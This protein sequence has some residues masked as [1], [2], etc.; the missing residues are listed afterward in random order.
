[1]GDVATHPDAGVAG[2]DAPARTTY[3]VAPQLVVAQ[4]V[5]VAVA[6]VPAPA[7]AST[8][9]S[10][11][12]VAW[13]DL[14]D[15]PTADRFPGDVLVVMEDLD[16]AGALHQVVERSRLPGHRVALVVP[17]ATRTR[18][19]EL[20]D[21]DVELAAGVE[22][23]ADFAELV[24]R[25]V[26]GEPLMAPE[27]RDRIRAEWCRDLEE[28]RDL[29]VRVRSLS[30]QQMRVLELLAAGLRV[31]EVA[32]VVGVTTGTVRTHVKTL[33]SRLGARTQ[34]EAVAMLRRAED[35]MAAGPVPRA[36]EHP[37]GCSDESGPAA[38]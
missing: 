37:S 15:D 11:R 6:T 21:S 2:Q 30:R 5:A 3:V 12:A 35:E 29:V 27:E 26:R 23:V 7:S 25:F 16:D 10:V 32:E 8:S 28:R 33:R 36:R 20:L 4:A 34:L 19:A 38:T 31:P 24:R 9:T 22:A 1:M 13:S 17:A 14:Y 18:S